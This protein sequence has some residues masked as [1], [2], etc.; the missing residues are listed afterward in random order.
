MHRLVDDMVRQALAVGGTCTGEHGVGIGKRE[1]LE[2]ELGPQAIAV[3]RAIKK[4][5]DP[6]LLLNPGK[7]FFMDPT[8]T[9][10]L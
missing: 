9:S 1:F 5:L 2:E 10:K 4:A 6:S 8:P 7:V 3:M